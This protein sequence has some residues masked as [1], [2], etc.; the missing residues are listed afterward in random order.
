MSN[1]FPEDERKK[2][3]ERLIDIGFDLLRKGGIKAVNID[4]LTEQCVRIRWLRCKVA[5]FNTNS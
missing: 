1:K 2:I 5:F 4:V 3:R